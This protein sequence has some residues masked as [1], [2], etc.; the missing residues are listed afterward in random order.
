LW[1]PWWFT[2]VC[3]AVDLLELMSSSRTDQDVRTPASSAPSNSTRSNESTG[4]DDGG[5]SPVQVLAGALAAVSAAVIASLFGVAGTVIGAAVASVVSTVG[6]AVY[7]SSLRRAH[8]RLIRRGG[9]VNRPGGGAGVRPL[10]ARLNP[11]RPP[12]RRWRR[13]WILAATAVGVFVLA[14]GVVTV[15]ELIGREPVSALV[16]GS[17]YSGGTTIGTL[18][19]AVGGGSS[20]Q[21]P[22]SSGAG[23]A[24]PS[25]ASGTSASRSSPTGTSRSESAAAG[26]NAS[27]VPAPSPGAADQPTSTR[28]AA[29]T[30]ATQASDTAASPTVAAPTAASAATVTSTAS[31]ASSP[32]VSVSPGQ[33]SN[34]GAAQPSSAAVSGP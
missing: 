4:R 30:Q 21:T 2:F 11:R 31:P 12:A 33:P 32:P 16:G 23:N 19:E 34:T 3:A 1:N 5:L 17:G 15:V 10:P 9:P 7:S 24:V 8:R 27:T 25:T 28:S 14:M 26:G 20:G 18:T 6:A 13:R 22:A 29:P